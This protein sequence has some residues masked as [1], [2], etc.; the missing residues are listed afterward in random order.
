V[1]VIAMRKEKPMSRELETETELEEKEE[2]KR[3]N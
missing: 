1:P 3:G 2:M